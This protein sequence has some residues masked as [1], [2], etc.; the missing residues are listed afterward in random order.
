M[1]VIAVLLVPVIWVLTSTLIMI[2]KKVVELAKANKT[3]V[4][5]FM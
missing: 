1:L 2:S 3:A 5:L 4:L